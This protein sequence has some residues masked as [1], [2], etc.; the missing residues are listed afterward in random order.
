VANYIAKYATKTLTVPGVPDTRIRTAFDLKGLR[1]SRHYRETIQIEERSG[2]RPK[3][4]MLYRYLLRAHI[5]PHFPSTTVAGLKTGAVRRWRKKLLD[6]GVSPV[7]TAK[8]SLLPLSACPAFIFTTC[9]M[10]ATSS[11]QTRA[12]TSAN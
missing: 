1:C 11:P 3:T 7:T 2:L 5:A 8:A 4:V 9:A 10:L 12:R 6:N